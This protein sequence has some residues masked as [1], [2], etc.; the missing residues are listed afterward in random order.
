MN[1]RRYF[2]SSDVTPCLSSIHKSF[3]C[4]SESYRSE[5]TNDLTKEEFLDDDSPMDAVIKN[6]TVLG[7]AVKKLPG[8]FREK[9]SHI[10]WRSIAGMRDN[11]V[12]EYFGIRYDVIWKTVVTRII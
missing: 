3:R 10:P 6:F 7:E 11:L 9:Y 5:L 2:A 12:H 8:E 4:F 1:R